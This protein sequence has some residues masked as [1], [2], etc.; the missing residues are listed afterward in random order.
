MSKTDK[1]IL[2]ARIL[3][4][5]PVPFLQQAAQV[6]DATLTLVEQ[7]HGLDL[8]DLR[9]EIAAAREPWQRI[10]DTAARASAADLGH[11]Y[12]STGE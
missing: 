2:I 12:G 10:H 11:P 8:S 1:A 4:H 9:A 5:V 3:E 7:E 6:V